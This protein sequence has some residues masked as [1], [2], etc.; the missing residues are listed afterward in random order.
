ML[1]IDNFYQFKVVYMHATS[2]RFPSRE[3]YQ[4]FFLER[5]VVVARSKLVTSLSARFL[6]PKG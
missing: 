6:C 2:H 1:Y 5:F 3:S 4:P